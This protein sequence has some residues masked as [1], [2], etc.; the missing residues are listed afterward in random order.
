MLYHLP[1]FFCYI[2][3]CIDEIILENRI[4]HDPPFSLIHFE[5]SLVF[6]VTIYSSKL[7]LLITYEYLITQ[8]LLWHLQIIH[9]SVHY[10][11]H[12]LGT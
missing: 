5:C 8:L 3:S 9:N 4:I 1:L 10:G 6:R 11:V 12:A 7:R 2:E